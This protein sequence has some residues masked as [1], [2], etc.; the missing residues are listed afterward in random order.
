MA[1]WKYKSCYFKSYT[2]DYPC[3]IESKKAPH[4]V[5]C[6]ICGCD[7]SVAHKG[8]GDVDGHFEMKKHVNNFKCIEKNKKINSAPVTSDAV[9]RA[10]CLFSAFILEHNLPIYCAD[11]ESLLFKKMFPDSAIA[12]KYACARTKTTSII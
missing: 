6:T 9:T 11:H 4:Y 12:K 7:F 3:I 8:K 2:T 1:G 10:E 5:F